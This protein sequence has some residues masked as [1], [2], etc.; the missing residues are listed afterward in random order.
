MSEKGSMISVSNYGNLKVFSVKNTSIMAVNTDLKEM[1]K[2]VVIW[3]L[4]TAM[5]L[6]GRL[7]LKNFYS[8]KKLEYLDMILQ[9]DFICAFI[10]VFASPGFTNVEKA[11][12]K[13]KN[14]ILCQGCK[15]FHSC[16][17]G[18][19]TWCDCCQ[20]CFP[21]TMNHC[22]FFGKCV[23]W[24][25]VPFAMMF[26]ICGSI[27]MMAWI[28]YFW[29]KIFGTLGLDLTMLVVDLLEGKLFNDSRIWIFVRIYFK[30]VIVV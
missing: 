8:E 21:W 5:K 27:M 16:T 2:I 10:M 24:R 23:T 14:Q 4:I 12:D 25:L 1:G 26:N 17:E 15:H 29:N 28:I 3:G 6:L 20:M 11:F 13:E 30:V 18:P 19:M 7:L 22:M 9:I